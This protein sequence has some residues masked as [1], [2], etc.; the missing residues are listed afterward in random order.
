[1]NPETLPLSIPDPHAEHDH[2]HGPDDFTHLGLRADAHMMSQPEIGRRR[3][4]GLGALG[5]G[6]LVGTAVLG[7]GV[8]AQA[9][10][11]T[12]ASCVITP[13]ETAGPFPADGS[14]ASGQT[15]NILQQSGIVRTDLTRSL[16]TGNRVSGVPMTLTMRLVSVAQ[17][18]APL[19]GH[20]I[21]VW[22]CTPD[23]RYS[24]YNQGV[25]GEDYLR[26]AAVTNSEGLVTFQAV[27]PG[28]YPGRWPHVHFEVYRNLAAAAQGNVGQNALLVSQLA[29]PE[30]VSRAVYADGRYGSSLRNL[31]SLSLERDMVFRDGVSAQMA[32]VTGS[33][34]AGYTA[35]I[36]VGIRS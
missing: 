27:F 18:C 20:V 1:M 22:M 6:A 34:S 17:N 2:D 15:L 5:I 31:G 10:T 36:A 16:G 12:A 11:G 29:L 7:R 24:L 21:Y 8:Q 23:G 25:T 28:C 30:N 26:G 32:Q 9:G 14:R 4:L 33:N 19:A 35:G 13:S 3:L